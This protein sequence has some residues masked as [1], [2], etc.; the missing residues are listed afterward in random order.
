MKYLSLMILVGILTWGGQPKAQTSQACSN[1]DQMKNRLENVYGEL[2]FWM[3]LSTDGSGTVILFDNKETTSWTALRYVGNEIACVIGMGS[4]SSSIRNAPKADSISIPTCE[5]EK[6]WADFERKYSKMEGTIFGSMPI[7]EFFA[8][9]GYTGNI[10]TDFDA[11]G[12]AGFEETGMGLTAYIKD[13]CPTDFQ[14]QSLEYVKETFF[15]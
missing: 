1:Y 12:F 7:Q 4:G 2:P 15:K 8:A 9:I 3:G 6:P 14:M 11:V 10:Q 13:G 5:D